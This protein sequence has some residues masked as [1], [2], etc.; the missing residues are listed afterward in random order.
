VLVRG[1]DHLGI[2]LVRD[3]EDVVFD[4]E[5]RDLPDHVGGSHRSGRV[6][7]RDEDEHAG[8]RGDPFLDFRDVEGEVVFLVRGHRHRDAA[9]EV[10]GG[11][12]GG[13]ARRGDEDLVARG[14][15]GEHGQHDAFLH[16]CG[17]HD[18]IG[19]VVEAVAVVEILGDGLPQGRKP[20]WPGVVVLVGVERCLG[21]VDDMPGVWKSGSPRPRAITPF[22]PAAMPSILVR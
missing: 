5:V 18:F 22:M 14:H 9:A 3:D 10:D 17:D 2:D 6:V 8:A 13:E 11:V 21:G 19:G 7:G 20:G 16:A 15:E 4:R 12:V 1:V